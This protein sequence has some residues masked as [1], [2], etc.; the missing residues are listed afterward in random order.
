MKNE[1]FINTL[2]RNKRGNKNDIRS[3]EKNFKCQSLKKGGEKRE[4]KR[5][6]GI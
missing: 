4:D 2:G 1:N 6:G 5:G 3:L